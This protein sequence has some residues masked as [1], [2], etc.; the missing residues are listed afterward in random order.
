MR[1]PF[2]GI[3]DVWTL[4]TLFAIL[5]FGSISQFLWKNIMIFVSV[6]VSVENGTWSHKI[7]MSKHTEIKYSHKFF[8]SSL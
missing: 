1:A 5:M 4:S 2:G 7:K 6:S 3:S 8:C